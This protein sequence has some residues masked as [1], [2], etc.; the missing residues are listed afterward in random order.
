MT[1]WTAVALADTKNAVT[2]SSSEPLADAAFVPA[3]PDHDQLLPVA[4]LLAATPPELHGGLCGYLSAGGQPLPQHWLEQLQIQP[5]ALDDQARDLLESLRRAATVLL[6][7]PQMRFQPLLPDD[8]TPMADRVAAL[9]QWCQA[10]LGGFGLAG[11][12]DQDGS[13][14]RREALTDLQRIAGFSYEAGEDEEDETALAEIVEFVRVA[15]LM[16]RQ[17]AAPAPDADGAV[18]H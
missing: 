18:R 3:L 8:D 7:D 6:D 4:R 16:L 12:S 2:D 9:M 1:H 14:S 10:F 11:G 17:E 13:A 5:V 15:A